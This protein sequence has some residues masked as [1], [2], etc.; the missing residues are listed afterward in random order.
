MKRVYKRDEQ[1][2]RYCQLD[3][4]FKRMGMGGPIWSTITMSIDMT[5]VDRFRKKIQEGS[6]VHISIISPIIKAAANASTAVPLIGGVWLTADKIW[7]AEP[8][9]ILIWGAVQVGDQ[10]GVYR[11]E[12]AGKKSLLEIS[13][14]LNAQVNQMR[15]KG[16]IAMPEEVVPR[17]PSLSITNVGTIG[18]VET[19][20]LQSNEPHHVGGNVAMLMAIGA[21]LEKPA[22]KDGKIQIRKLMNATLFW[23]HSAMMANT[24]IE[25]LNELKRNLE[26]PDT[27]LV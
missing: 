22:V 20:T 26:E 4:Q 18:P 3:E 24:P 14:E 17:G 12:K 1:G 2:R 19:G 11:V 5:D 27:F 21:I 15:S 16:K 9:E 10:L 8:G 25:F 13:K 7:V 23:D 6:E